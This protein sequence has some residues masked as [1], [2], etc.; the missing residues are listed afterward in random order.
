MNISPK[1]VEN[2]R[3][4]ADPPPPPPAMAS[5]TCTN[6]P[7]CFRSGKQHI[8]YLSAT[9]LYKR[10]YVHCKCTCDAYEYTR[11]EHARSCTCIC[12][13]ISQYIIKLKRFSTIKRRMKCADLVA[14][15]LWTRNRCGSLGNLLLPLTRYLAH[16]PQMRSIVAGRGSGALQLQTSAPP[17]PWG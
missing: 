1:I 7:I 12:N 6:P 10:T 9:W 11:V 16:L 3:L 15:V 2:F 17:I 4:V 5:T 13:V 8:L 14:V